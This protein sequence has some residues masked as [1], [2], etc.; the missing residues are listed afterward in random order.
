MDSWSDDYTRDAMRG[1][2]EVLANFSDQL[3]M[4]LTPHDHNMTPDD[5]LFLL[6]QVTS[7]AE[8]MRNTCEVAKQAAMLKPN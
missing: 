8:S 7:F 3:K 4:R 5:V 2:S 1:S 6:H